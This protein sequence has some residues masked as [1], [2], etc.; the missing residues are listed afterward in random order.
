MH[1]LSFL[2]FDSL[3]A[4]DDGRSDGARPF[5]RVDLLEI[6]RSNRML[7]GAHPRS[8]KRE[9]SQI[10]AIAQE[11][12]MIG[13]V[14]EIADI[15][16]DLGLVATALLEPS[17]PISRSTG[18]SRLI[19]IQRFVRITSSYFD[20]DARDM[21]EHLDALL[22][23]KS[24]TSWHSSGILVAGT[25]H[26]RRQ[27]GPTLGAQDLHRILQF[28]GQGRDRY[29]VRNHALVSLH[30]FSGLRPEEIVGLKW[31]HVNVEGR[32]ADSYALSV[33]VN[34]Q[35]TSFE[36]P[37]PRQSAELLIAL[38][39][40]QGGTIKSLTGP[41]FCPYGGSRQTLS[42]RSARDILKSACRRAG[43][44]AVEAVDL[45]AA[46]AHWLRAQG[47]S[48]HE[49]ASVLGL[50]RVR[51]VDRLLNRHHALDAQR[52]VRERLDT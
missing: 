41:V 4:A 1:Q 8:V 19:S 44:P 33:S 23:S 11:C 38:A 12:R 25:R 51:S 29:S 22:P 32:E 18:R 17:K 36:L 26:R 14:V 2:E 49:V 13:G 45:R 52:R 37:L 42:Y 15:F 47:L 10:R 6:Y 48:D 35:S 43:F 30:C 9:I 16:A 31:P 34:R 20:C 27:R 3:L 39:Y 40:S 24:D 7:E 5:D 50:E 28:T 46:Y 21:L